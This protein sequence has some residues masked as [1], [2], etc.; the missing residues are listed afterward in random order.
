MSRVFRLLHLQNRS[1]CCS[2]RGAPGATRF[3][4]GLGEGGLHF[5]TS[6]SP[7][8]PAHPEIRIH[9]RFVALPFPHHHHHTDLTLF[10]HPAQLWRL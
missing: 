7:P 3:G 5:R 4:V 9:F 1:Y 2:P 8:T 6:F 10:H